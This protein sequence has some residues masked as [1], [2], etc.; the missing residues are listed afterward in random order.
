MMGAGNRSW[1]PVKPPE[2]H[3]NLTQ[4]MGCHH[5]GARIDSTSFEDT[6]LSQL[7]GKRTQAQPNQFDAAID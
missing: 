6:V 7:R 4:R 5:A 2:S 1:P 3:E